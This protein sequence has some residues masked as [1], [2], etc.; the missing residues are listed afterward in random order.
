MT[1]PVTTAYQQ[2]DAHTAQFEQRA[3]QQTTQALRRQL[4]QATQQIT[5]IYLRLAGGLDQPLPGPARRP[6][7][8]TCATIIAAVSINIRDT[9]RGLVALALNIGRQ[10]A[11]PYLPPGAEIVTTAAVL[12]WTQTLV[13]TVDDRARAQLLSAQAQPHISIPRTY[14]D[15][16]NIIA[17]AMRALSLVER[18][19]RWT[20]N[21]AINTGVREITDQAGIVRMWVAE[22]DA[23]L[24]CLAYS[25]QTA[26]PGQPYPTGLTYYI[27]PHSNLKPL[28]YDTVWGPTLHPS[29]R[30]MQ[31]PYLG[32]QPDYPV[33]PWEAGPVGPDE[34]LRRE[35]R[36]AVVRGQSGSDSLPARLRAAD[37]LLSRGA[38][39]PKSVEAR[40]RAAVMAGRFG[41]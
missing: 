14:R 20:V 16:L 13:G 18:D 27:D 31:R 5:T 33:H 38:G 37:V 29:C 39:L 22:R 7:A 34:A 21:N 24:H 1:G 26:Q 23:C 32:L 17:Q 2:L 19:T 6:F 41:G 4:Q 15:V 30:C 8:D 25:G 3:T 12:E 36:R 40:S 35:A 10:Q 9:L 11:T 28:N